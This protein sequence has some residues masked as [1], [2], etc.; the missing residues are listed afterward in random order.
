MDEQ[1]TSKPQRH[2]RS[3]ARVY[4]GEAVVISPDQNRVRML[5]SVGTRIWELAD[6]TRTPV[7]IANALTEEYEVPLADAQAEVDAFL[8]ELTEKGVIVWY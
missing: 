2:P 1:Q 6:G 3:A 4:D 5:N 7:Q 8:A